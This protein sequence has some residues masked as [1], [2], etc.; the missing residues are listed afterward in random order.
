MANTKFDLIMS[1]S[2]IIKMW[3]QADLKEHE[4]FM[5]WHKLFMDG[6]KV[7]LDKDKAEEPFRVTALF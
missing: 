2:Q 7:G 1:N 4:E 6:F 3:E 5:K